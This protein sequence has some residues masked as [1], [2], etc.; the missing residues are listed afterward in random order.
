MEQEKDFTVAIVERFFVAIRTLIDNGVLR[1]LQT[2]TR[3]YDINR[4]NLQRLEREPHSG[5][6]HAGW[7]TYLVVDFKISPAWLLTGRGEIFAEGWDAEMVRKVQMTGKLKKPT[8]K[9]SEYQ[10][11]TT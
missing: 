6:F 5:M 3:R 4:R 9:A 10:S 7:L 8:A 2:F 11:V 1:G